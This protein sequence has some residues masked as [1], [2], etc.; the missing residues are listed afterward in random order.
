MFIVIYQITF[1]IIYIQEDS[2]SL[3]DNLCGGRL[4]TLVAKQV[5]IPVGLVRERNV[6]AVRR[7]LANLVEAVNV[8][9]LEVDLL[10][11]VADAARRDRLGDDGVPADLGPGEEDV[12]G[13]DGAALGDGETLGDG[14]DLVVD[15]EEG[16][17]D[18]VVAK[19]RVGGQ[20]DVLVGAVLDELGLEEA[21]VALDLVGGGDDAGGLDDVFELESK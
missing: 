12:G 2:H 8:L 19:G 13:A 16:G 17:A 7:R 18:G 9:L 3:L 5:N 6:E 4:F 21:R 20:D 14:L 11:V 1:I 10:K 15:E